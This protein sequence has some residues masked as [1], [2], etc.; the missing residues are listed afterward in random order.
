MPKDED[1]ETNLQTKKM[2]DVHRTY[3]TLHCIFVASNKR[4]ET[5]RRNRL[6]YNLDY[7]L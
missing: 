1:L 2:F 7:N 6:R 3:T 5:S 4:L